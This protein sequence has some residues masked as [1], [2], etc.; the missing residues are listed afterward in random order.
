VNCCNSSKNSLVAGSRRISRTNRLTAFKNLSRVRRPVNSATSALVD[1]LVI[2]EEVQDFMDSGEAMLLNIKNDEI[3][4]ELYRRAGILAEDLIYTDENGNQ[5][6][7]TVVLGNIRNVLVPALADALKYIPIPKIQ[8]SNAKREY[9]VDNIVLC[10]YD[11]VPENISVKMESDN[12]FNVR[13]IEGQHN[14]SRL[15]ISI[16][17]IRTEIKDVWFYFHRKT[18]PKVE[19]RGRVSVRLDGKGAELTITFRISHDSNADPN[20]IPQLIEGHVDFDIHSL[21][22][23]FDKDTLKHEILVPMLTKLFKSQIV[24]GIEKGV[25]RNLTNLIN[26]LGIALGEVIGNTSSPRF[27]KQLAMS[28][29]KLLKGEFARTYQKRQ[30]RLE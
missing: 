13:K 8:D 20:M 11:I 18:F 1:Q 12:N 2:K 14:E 22:I 15:V 25:E 23:K 21:D 26:K 16:K 17:N 19:E 29:E 7:D 4:S 30:E 24:S 6:L 3:L 9:A 28:R 10:G 27:L 5:Q